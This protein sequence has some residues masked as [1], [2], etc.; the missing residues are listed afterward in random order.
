MGGAREPRHLLPPI[1]PEIY[2][3]R[4]AK[5]CFRSP[6]PHTGVG[7]G[8]LSLHLPL[9]LPQ[10]PLDS[11]P[12]LDFYEVQGRSQGGPGVPVTPLL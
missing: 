1:T 11:L 4:R 7:K 8:G 9:P 3:A 12:M 6:S 2:R 10:A 5:R